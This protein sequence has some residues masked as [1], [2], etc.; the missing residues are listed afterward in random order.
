MHA[1]RRSSYR[2]SAERTARLAAG[3]ARRLKPRSRVVLVM[4]NGPE[5]IEALWAIFWAGMVA[6]PVNR[7]LHPRELGYVA[8]HGE[9]S[10]LIYDAAT[11]DAVSAAVVGDRL[12]AVCAEGAEWRAL[13]GE[14]SA[15]PAPVSPDDPAWL[16]YTSGTTGRP[17]GATLTH[18]NLVAMAL[19][20][21]ADVDPVAP[22]TV[23]LHAAPLSHGSGLYLLPAIGHGATNVISDS[24]SF[25]PGRFLSLVREHAVTHAAFLVPTMLRRL[26]DAARAEG[27]ALPTLRHITVGGSHLYEQ[28]LADALEVFGP[29]VTQIYGQGEAPMTISAMQP[30]L[31]TARDAPDT[32]WRSC[33]RPFTGV[34]IRIG[35]GRD[36]GDGGIWVRGDVVMSGYWNDPEATAAALV[37]GWL[38][39]G[40]IGR[41]DSRGFLY[42][43]DRAKDVIISGGSNIYPR[44]VEEALL[45]HPA[46]REAIVVGVPD[47]D[48]GESVRAY[49]VLTQGAE[50]GESELIDHCRSLIASYKKPRSVRFMD[51]LPKS[52]NGKLLRKALK[53]LA[54]ES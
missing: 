14:P 4:S 7:H 15:G 20:Y 12:Q 8:E 22:G 3:L 11:R 50:V 41:L 16:F 17:K 40:G 25:D 27:R 23:C 53:D 49:V 39:T 51:E 45:L 5:F 33:G 38:A 30:G 24:E 26:T 32:N 34:E 42:L 18:R 47:P 10:M 21:Y 29:I 35:D 46:V 6:V 36:H 1:G 52:A 13:E 31:L 48:W 37:E 44:E 19:N 28:D 54:A 43:T 2:D 9:A